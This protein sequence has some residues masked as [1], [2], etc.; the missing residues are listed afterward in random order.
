MSISVCSQHMLS[1]MCQGLKVT[2]GKAEFWG[3]K[4]CVITRFRVCAL[5]GNSGQPKSPSFW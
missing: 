3:S 5:R 2:A 1:V 4:H